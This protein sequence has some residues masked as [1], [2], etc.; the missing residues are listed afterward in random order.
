MNT[1]VAE[2]LAGEGREAG[3]AEIILEAATWAA[4]ALAKLRQEDIAAILR[5]V[6]APPVTD[7]A[8]A[9]VSTATAA[10]TQRSAIVIALHPGT[11]IALVEAARAIAAA[12]EQAGA[13]ACTLQ[14]IEGASPALTDRLMKP[15]KVNTILDTHSKG[16]GDVK[17]IHLA[18]AA[19]PGAAAGRLPPVL[20]REA[21]MSLGK[22]QEG[23]GR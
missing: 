21:P 15:A 2:L 8:A 22:L 16:G 14:V 20:G 4:A 18:V 5:A 6:A 10:L 19:D 12:A 7:S 9:I 11:P 3:Q 23:A 1:I 17:W 13:P